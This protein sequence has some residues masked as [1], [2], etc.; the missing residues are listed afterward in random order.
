MKTNQ[1]HKIILSVAAIVMS[2]L[3][4]STAHADEGETL[5]IDNIKQ[6]YWARGEE[7]ELGVVQNRAYSKGRK[8]E[9]GLLGGVT[10][11]D[12]FLKI[13]Q[14]GFEAGWHLSE[15]IGLHLIAWKSIVASSSALLT[16]EQE[17]QA[18]TNTNKPR[19]FYGA[20]AMGSLMYKAQRARQVDHLLRLPSPRGRR[21]HRN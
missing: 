3:A 10:F 21:A 9:L 12:P 2:L 17:K 16:F 1:T 13:Q 5:N 19:D 20:E 11:S 8:F 4:D 15:S 18:T 14:V 7:A 6:K